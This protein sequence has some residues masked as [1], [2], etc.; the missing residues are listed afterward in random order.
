MGKKTKVSVS[1]PAET[2]DDI[3]EMAGR[4][5]VS[6]GELLRRAVRTEKLLNR[7][8]QE[9]SQLLVKKANGDLMDIVRRQNR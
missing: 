7:I 5:G 6:A 2:V 3:K 8:E 9:G 1:L 4:F